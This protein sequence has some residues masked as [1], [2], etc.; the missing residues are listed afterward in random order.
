[1][2]A[3]VMYRYN[4]SGIPVIKQSKLTGIITKSDIVFALAKEA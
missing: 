2:A 1:M 3:L 4:I